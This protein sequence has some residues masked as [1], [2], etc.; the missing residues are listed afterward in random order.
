VVHPLHRGKKK[1]RKEEKKGG[2]EQDKNQLQGDAAGPRRDCGLQEE[3]GKAASNAV[4]KKKGRTHD[5]ASFGEGRRVTD[6][7]FFIHQTERGGPKGKKKGLLLWCPGLKKEE[8]VA[9]RA[10]KK[11][12]ADALGRRS[13]PGKIL[14]SLRPPRGDLRSIWSIKEKSGRLVKR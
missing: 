14:S 2:R 3:K 6:A 12:K 11:K 4:L 7:F 13:L 1:G 9:A 5:S 8:R 10:R